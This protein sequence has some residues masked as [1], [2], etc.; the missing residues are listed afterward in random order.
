MVY[1]IEF[2]PFHPLCGKP[3]PEA[4]SFD[5]IFDDVVTRFKSFCSK[6][7]PVEADTLVIK[8]ASI[9]SRG[10]AGIRRV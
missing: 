1:F 5:E 6:N 7:E 9:S 2:R 8:S 4:K 3:W 10:K